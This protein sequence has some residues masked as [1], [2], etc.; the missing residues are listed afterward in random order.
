MQSGSA[1]VMADLPALG[2]IVEHGVTGLLYPAGNVEA[3]SNTIQS[4]IENENLRSELGNN[5]KK[6]VEQNRTWSVV[7]DG[8]LN[9][10]QTA[11]K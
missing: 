3:L 5:A 2:E 6:W 11:L 7:I 10:Y 4:L 1:V 8:A 9:A